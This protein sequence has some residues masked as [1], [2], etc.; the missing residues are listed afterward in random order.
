[1]AFW[2]TRI[3][4]IA[5]KLAEILQDETKQRAFAHNAR[6][7]SGQFTIEAHVDKLEALYR[8]VITHPQESF[9]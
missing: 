7:L 1:M 8:Q 5:G 4:E 6:T 9:Q 2:W 3:A